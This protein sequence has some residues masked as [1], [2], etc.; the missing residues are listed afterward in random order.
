MTSEEIT[1]GI[2]EKILELRGHPQRMSAGLTTEELTWLCH[3]VRP[4]FLQQPIL[5]ELRPPLT[6]C[7]DVHGQF[8]DLI[9]IFEINQYP[10]NESYLFLGDYVDRGMHSIECISILFCYKILYPLNFFMLRGNHECTYINR[11]FGFFD[12]CMR[13]YTPV[14]WRT[15]S[16]VF[17]CLP[18]A[19]II[20]DRIFCLHGGI[21]PDLTSL[22]DIRNVERPFEVPEEGL[23]CDLLWADPSPYV[24]TWAE[25]DRGT[26]VLFG[27]EPLD[28][29]LNF[30]GFDLV[31]RA[32]QAVMGGYEFPFFPKQNLVTVF[33]APNY[34]YHFDNYAA[35][36]KV[37]EKLFC[38]FCMLDPR[39]YEVN[40]G[41]ERRM[42]NQPA[43]Q[44]VEMED[45]S[46]DSD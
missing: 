44:R 6:V 43:L 16:D 3:T 22:D 13:Y 1:R 34:C 4:I 35:I 29:F 40:C 7:G 46:D 26:S 37:D 12:D 21:S 39:P 24:E 18:I 32:H 25:N 14:I 45:D 15:F 36:L 27:A 31:C 30:F 42:I 8:H 5:L 23:L 17:N 10:G 28:E 20:D 9:R 38:T 19:A 11:L 33:S 41:I 2:L